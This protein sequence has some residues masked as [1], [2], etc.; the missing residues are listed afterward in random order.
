MGDRVKVSLFATCL[1][2]MFYPNAGKA[3]VNLLRHFNVE[4]DFPQGQTC[5]GQP[6]YNS[7][8]MNETRQ[9]AKQ[10]IRAFENSE[11][12][13]GLSG[14]CSSMLR[15]NYVELFEGDPEWYP[16]AVALSKKVYE[17]SQFFVDVLG[18]TDVGAELEAAVTLHIACHT[19]RGMEV[20]DQPEQMLRAVKGLR[21]VPLPNAED[22]CGFGGTFSVKNPEISEEMV[23][24]KSEHVE[25]TGAEI[26]VG[27]DM[28]CLMNIGGRLRHNEKPIPMMHI[29]EI[30]ERGL[31]NK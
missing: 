29:A 13:I 2:D 16:K 28:A 1:T 25:E 11:Y 26:L 23:Q 24:E 21:F 27:T 19:R 18:V 17:F 7:G 3:A 30:L 4:V 20:V 15:K 8:Y 22:C 31:E 6:A 9:A 12:I 5:C 10:I 14:S